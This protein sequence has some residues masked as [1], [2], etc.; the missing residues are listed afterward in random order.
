[1]YDHAGGRVFIVAD[2]EDAQEA[3]RRFGTRRGEVWTPAE[4]ELVGRIEDQSIRDEVANFKRQLDGC[5]S[6][7]AAIEG[8]ST[9]ERK[10]A[11]L[12]RLFQEQGKTGQPGRITAATVRHGERKAGEK[13]V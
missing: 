1:M 7:G 2:Q 12:N 3:I 8:I 6:L 10:A 11:A 5:L 9:E 4:I 13:E